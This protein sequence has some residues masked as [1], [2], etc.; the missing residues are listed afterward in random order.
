MNVHHKGVKIMKNDEASKPRFNFIRKR[1]NFREWLGLDIL[2]DITFRL[3]N[4]T[5]DLILL[6]TPKEKDSFEQVQAKLGLN[7]AD[8]LIRQNR[9]AALSLFMLFLAAAMFVYLIYQCR[10][11]SYRGIIIT[12]ALVSMILGFAFRYHFWYMQ[13][14][15]KKLGLTL[16]EW[17]HYT[18][19][20]RK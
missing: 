2:I 3:I 10:Y 4:M 19:Y 6:P 16:N 1:L 7:S 18:V 9:L 8:I 11:G 13:F 17:F 14:R 12:T 20:G 15:E 5:R